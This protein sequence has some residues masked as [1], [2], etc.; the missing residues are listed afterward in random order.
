MARQDEKQRLRRRLQDYAIQLVGSNS[1]E[2]AI[3]VNRQ[4]LE[5]G[6]D[7][8]T[9]NRLGKALMEQGRY[10]EAHDAYQQTL[11]LNP[12]NSIARR[13][14]SRLESLLSRGN[15]EEII[16]RTIRQQV[17]LRFFIKEA[18]KTVLT[19]LVD[20]PRSP[21]VE[22]LATGERV[23]IHIEGRRALVI[24]VDGSII[25]RLEPKIGQRLAEL[26]GGGNRYVAA[27]VQS[28][29]RQVRI[30]IREVYQDPSQLGRTSFPSRLVDDN[31]YEYMALRYDYD[32]EDLL[33][34]EET[35]EVQEVLA[36]EFNDSGDEDVIRLDS[37][38][39]NIGD[40][41]DSEDE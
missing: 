9:Y 31:A 15:E 30:L 20:V 13:N 40:D 1:W 22:A 18:G 37:I 8:P 12:I 24:D 41:D 11:R 2:E 10:A 5:L 23:E 4:I 26:I 36:D 7:P 14:L 38:E 32:S 16:A 28:D 19:T 17:D 34:E 27:V 35:P 29:V 33:D 39:K 25:G 21:N 3:D 6:E